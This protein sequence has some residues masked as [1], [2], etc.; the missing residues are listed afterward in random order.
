[1]EEERYLM[2]LLPWVFLVVLALLLAAGGGVLV[3][4][5]RR[6]SEEPVCNFEC[7]HCGRKLRYHG[8]KMGR[9]GICPL[10]RQPLTYPPLPD[11]PLRNRRT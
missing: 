10:C 2:D 5:T 3:V 4:R 9:A 11:A 6:P 1:M 8:R 7:P